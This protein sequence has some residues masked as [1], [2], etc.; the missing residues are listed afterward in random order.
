[1]AVRAWRRG[2]RLQLHELPSHGQ[3]LD[4]SGQELSVQGREGERPRRGKLAAW[5]PRL[6]GH[7]QLVERPWGGQRPGAA[8]LPEAAESDRNRVATSCSV[9]CCENRGK[10]A[11]AEREEEGKKKKGKAGNKRADIKPEKVSV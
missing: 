1:M 7:W 8:G 9:F 10:D 11:A 2:G 5:E 3:E 6:S 4:A